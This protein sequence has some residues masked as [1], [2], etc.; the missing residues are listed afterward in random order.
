MAKAE[1][2]GMAQ[3]QRTMSA[4]PGNLQQ[5]ALRE[6]VEKAAEVFR[7][8]AAVHAPRDTGLLARSIYLR[9]ARARKFREQYD[10]RVRA[11][12]YYWTFQEFGTSTTSPQPFMRP[13]FHNNKTKARAVFIESFRA[14]IGPAVRNSR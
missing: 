10:V 4:F 1:I 3:L 7:S 5:T 14:A 2:R 6:S 11:R 8:D 12:A 9:R 13:A